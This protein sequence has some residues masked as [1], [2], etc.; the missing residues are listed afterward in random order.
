MNRREFITLLGGATVACPLSARAQ[1]AGPPVVGFLSSASLETELVAFRAGLRESG[2]IEGRDVS[3]EY[4]WAHDEGD[5]LPPLAA[6]LVRRQVSVIIATNNAATL[7]AKSA[8]STIP[9]VFL[10]SVD[11]VAFGLAATLN[12][13]GGNLTGVTTLNVELLPK[14]LQLLQEVIP[15][16]KSM[17]LL[18]NPTNP[19]AATDAQNAQK[20]ASALGLQLHIQH[21]STAPEFT[22]AFAD[23][24]RLQVGGL[25]IAADR[26]FN[27]RSEQLAA[28]ALHH[29]V[30]T[31]YQY[32]DF[33]AAGGLMSYGSSNTDLYRQGG[34]Y[35]GRILRG[36]KPGDMP[37]QQSTKFQLIVNVKTANTLGLTLPP[38]LLIRADEVVE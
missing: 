17:A 27:T 14:R 13:P 29:A 28:L 38:T 23:V 8:T 4:R 15:R 30:P 9:I 18:I 12:R 2:Y 35:I 32:R 1:Q 10:V 34:V 3:V 26:F 33:A 19:A 7:A 24:V 6:D 20:A 16:A 25:A 21:A 22:R 31:V 36:E 37:V 5:R 11:P